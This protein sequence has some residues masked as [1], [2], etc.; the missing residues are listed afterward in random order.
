MVNSISQ[1]GAAVK[2]YFLFD[3][4]HFLMSL[5]TK[6]KINAFQILT[7]TAVKS[8]EVMLQFIVAS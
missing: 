6:I 8:H 1:R 3:E 4:G 2:V 7:K 5:K